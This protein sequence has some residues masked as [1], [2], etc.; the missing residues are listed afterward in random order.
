MSKKHFIGIDLGTTFSAVSVFDETGRPQI[1]TNMDGKNITP[2]CV[3]K[4]DD[5]YVI[6]EEARKVWAQTS[7]GGRIDTGE[8]AARFKREMGTDKK[9]SIGDKKFVPM[10]LSAMVLK[11]LVQDAEQ[12]LGGKIEG[13]VV[14]VPANFGHEARDATKSAVEQA[15]LKF[16]GI[17]DEP[18]A[19]AL[20]YVFEGKINES[21]VYAVYDL[22]GGTF[23]ISIIRVDGYNVEVLA[24]AGDLDLGGDN[25]DHALHEIV[26]DKY[27]KET[28]N[29][30]DPMDYDFNDVEEDKKSLSKIEKRKVKVGKNLIEVSRKEFEEQIQ[31]LV[32]QA[33]ELCEAAIR[34]AKEKGISQSDI[35]GVL[36]AGG[37]T[38]IPLVLKSIKNTFELEQEPVEAE[39]VDEVVS[40]GAAV[41]A[42]HLVNSDNKRQGGESGLSRIQ[43]QSI[44][45][46]SLTEI[47]TMSFG[48]TVATDSGEII[49]D[50]L[51]SKGTKLPCSI[52]KTYSTVV[53]GQT[54]VSCD[55]TEAMQDESNPEY[56]KILWEGTLKLPAPHGPK[57]RKVPVTFSYDTNQIM[58]CVFVDEQSGEKTEVSLSMTD[59]AKGGGSHDIK[60]LSVE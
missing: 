50:V 10:E 57:G 42:G 7:E 3:A 20:C 17:N 8:A 47:S 38:R 11:K 51:I 1:V 22:G 35:K 48:T 6:G 15:G 39:N 19:A 33:E 23:D 37:S 40:K 30:M 56:V 43:E 49:N 53:D 28:G 59:S 32:A 14:T 13:A 58:H 16:L 2:S 9:Y 45:K 41:Y 26:S 54:G 27:K 52:E 25:F 44:Q 18:S 4:I 12:R 21:G 5:K 34:K 55:V 36:L 46:I 24:T 31:P 60:K 29:P